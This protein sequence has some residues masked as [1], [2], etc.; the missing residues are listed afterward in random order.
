MP[1]LADLW[2]PILVA[3]VLVFVVSSLVHMVLQIHKND[4][5]PLPNEAKV[6]EALRAAG[7]QPGSYRFPECKSMKEMNA[8]EMQE[9]L[10][11]GPVGMLTVF[12]NGP[13][14]MGKALGQWFVFCIVVGVFVA[15][16]AGLSVPRGAD[17]MA[18]FRVTTTVAFIGFS[19]SSVCDSIWK[20]VSWG[21]TAKFVF[22]GI[23]YAVSTGVAFAWLWPGAAA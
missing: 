18:V 11:R 19:L 23:L 9:K 8:P 2:L 14:A 15:Y 10:R 6:T 16:L 22:D 7:L 17:F 21:V 20:G 1:A 13:M 4:F 12:P 5:D 3:A